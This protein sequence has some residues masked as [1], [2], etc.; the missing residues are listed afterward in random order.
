MSA[1]LVALAVVTLAGIFLASD[2]AIGHFGIYILAPISTLAFAIVGALLVARVPRNPVG[3]LL[4]C[5]GL[6]FGGTLALANYA[7]AALVERPGSLP[8]GDVAAVIANICFVP[9]ILCVVLMLF[10]FPSGHG[11]GGRWT[12]IERALVA[13]VM[14]ITI[15]G[16]FNDGTIEMSSVDGAALRIA[17]PLAVRDPIA[18][19][20]VAFLVFLNGPWS[21]PVV[22][23]GPLSLFVRYRRASTVERQQIKWLAYSAT[24]GLVILVVSDLAPAP[25]ADL[26]WPVMLAALGLIPFAIAIAIFR[27]RLYDIDVI[28][29][30][31]LVYATLSGLLLGGYLTAIALVEAFLASFTAANQI[32][33][34]VSTVAVI[35]LFQPLR[36]RVQTVVDRRFYRSRFDAERILDAFA[37][38]LRD[39]VDLR[40]LETELLEVVERTV[41]PA[42]A[43][44]WLR[45]NDPGTPAR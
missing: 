17:N 42:H 23:L 18:A 13:L 8:F 2:L 11:L 29:R 34:A 31:T 15:G 22:L 36:R 30:R 41:R 32:A 20:V 21:T 5:A 39:E 33:I 12:W 28:I 38:R 43:S 26:A 7:V 24:L 40:A 25:V 4:A 35:A 3:Y 14:G 19:S 6:L 10:F 45:R 37:S 16:L 9:G 27:Y 1:R 44:L